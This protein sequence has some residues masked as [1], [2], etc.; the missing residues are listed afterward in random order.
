MPLIL[1]CMDRFKVA[2]GGVENYPSTTQLH[3][4]V[5]VDLEGLTNRALEMAVF[6][7]ASPAQDEGAPF[8]G[9][10]HSLDPH[11][12]CH[13]SPCWTSGEEICRLSSCIGSLC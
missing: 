3:L 11:E 6:Q 4:L 5:D 9:I 10:G 7:A 12:D 13:Y 2:G 8:V 1:G